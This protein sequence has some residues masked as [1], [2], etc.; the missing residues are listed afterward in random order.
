MKKIPICTSE[1]STV[2]SNR[3]LKSDCGQ[4]VPCL[5]NLDKSIVD[6]VI[7]MAQETNRA[8]TTPHA[9]IVVSPNMSFAYAYI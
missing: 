5:R 7:E 8:T 6:S 9:A 3:G 1:D 4:V 2:I